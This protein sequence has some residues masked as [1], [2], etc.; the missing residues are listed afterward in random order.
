[1]ELR[2]RYARRTATRNLAVNGRTNARFSYIGLYKVD[3]CG[4]GTDMAVTQDGRSLWGRATDYLLGRN[5]LIGVASFMLLII[6]GLRHLARHAR[7]HH[8]RLVHADEPGPGAARRHVVLQRRARHRRRRRAHLP[9]VADAARDV[10]R[11]ARTLRERL[12]HLPA[13]RVPRH[14]VDRLRLRL[15]VEPDL[16][17]GGDAHRACRPAGGRARRQRRRSPPGSMRCAASST[18][19]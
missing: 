13:L 9:D 7:L 4:R 2:R 17:R 6:S 12:D 16:R 5:T 15:L 11:Q 19:W 14:L 10:R 8:R 18:A 1:M 3:D